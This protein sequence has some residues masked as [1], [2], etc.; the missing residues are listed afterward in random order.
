MTPA[1]VPTNAATRIGFAWAALCVSVWTIVFAP[2]VV[3]HSTLRPGARTFKIWASLWARATLL[4]SG[5]R[6]HVEDRACLAPGTP[7]VFVANHVNALDILTAAAGVPYPFGFAAKASLRRLPLIGWVLARTACLF[8]DR[9]TPRKAAESVIVAADRLRRGDAVLLFPEGGRS[10]TGE[11][12]SFQRGAFVLAIQA[13]APLV[14]VALIG[15]ERLFDER[16]RSFRPGRTRLVVGPPIET[17][18]RGKAA[19]QELMIEV[20]EWMRG[21]LGAADGP[22]VSAGSAG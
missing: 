14:P 13:G 3:L 20:R 16:R 12:Q 4:T 11:L 5:V 8:V 10:W 19:V 15:N 1:A 21:E 9:S 22:A 2:L 17:A 18:G 6:L 7:A